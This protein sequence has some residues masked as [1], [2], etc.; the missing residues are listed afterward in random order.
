MKEIQ[1]SISL[2]TRAP[3]KGEKHGEDYF[4]VSEKEFKEKKDSDGL[5]ESALVHGYWYGTP[6]DSLENHLKRGTDVLLDIDVQGGRQILKLFPEAVLIFI[7]PPSLE[8][9]ESRLRARRQDSEETIQRRLEAAR[10]EIQASG[11]YDY[12]IVNEK[13]PQAVDQLRCV[14][15]AERSR[16]ARNRADVLNRFQEVHHSK[17]SK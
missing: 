4:F 10:R 14:I 6:K 5:I 16:M 3:R 7:V 13:L 15:L 17:A 11:N 9:L 8:V 2:T 12:V 1:Y